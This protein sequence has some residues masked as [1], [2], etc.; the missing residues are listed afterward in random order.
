M[1]SRYTKRDIAVIVTLLTIIVTCIVLL[2][3]NIDFNFSSDSNKTYDL[4]AS[5]GG[6]PY[7]VQTPCPNTST[8]LMVDGTA[9]NMTKVAKYKII[10]R[11]ESIS[12]H[13]GIVDVSN[14][15]STRDFQ[16]SFGEIALDKNSN[17]INY[18]SSGRYGSWYCNSQEFLKEYGTFDIISKNVSNNHIVPANNE[19]KKISESVK[20]GNVV[21]IEGYLSTYKWSTD[22]GEHFWGTSTSRDDTGNNACETIYVESLKIIQ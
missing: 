20:V 3:L 4:S 5:K 14:K 13:Y 1:Y 10:G 22:K 7:P 21:D 11:V 6:L 12:Y 9:V 15:L 8:T 16:L 19:I 17:R 18:S 2:I